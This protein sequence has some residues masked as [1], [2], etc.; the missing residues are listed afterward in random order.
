MQQAQETVPALLTVNELAEALRLSPS[1]IYGAIE[2][3]EIQALRV[4]SRPGASLRV[5]ASELSDQ[6]APRLLGVTASAER[7]EQLEVERPAS[8]R[9]R[10]TLLPQVGNAQ[11]R[12]SSSATGTD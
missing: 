1:A 4:T 9:H 12:A 6:P 5:P 7:D 2:A 10:L 3:G 11:L 8:Q